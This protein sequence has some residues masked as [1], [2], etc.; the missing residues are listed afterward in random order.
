MKKMLSIV[1][2]SSILGSITNAPKSQ[3]G[4][5][6]AVAGGIVGT[7][8]L[9]LQ[10]PGFVGMVVGA[11]M[12]LT[13]LILT[14]VPGTMAIGIPLFVLNEDGSLS[15][16]QL[17]S[18]LSQKFNFIADREVISSLACMIK[19]KADSMEPDSEGKKI[20]SLSEEEVR[21]ILA[22]IDLSNEE[23]ALVIKNLK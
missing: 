6:L 19:Q 12:G 22:P 18:L 2:I 8:V 11:P 14:W 4:V 20:V 5:I 3:A 7:N 13:G 21:A 16:D 1:L 10:V 9:G 17:E 23:I 15:K